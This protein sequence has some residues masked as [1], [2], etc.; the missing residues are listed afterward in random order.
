MR[1]LYV[2]VAGTIRMMIP[3]DP[4]FGWSAESGWEQKQARLAAIPSR[5]A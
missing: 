4:W 5:S 1:L 3:K 2:E